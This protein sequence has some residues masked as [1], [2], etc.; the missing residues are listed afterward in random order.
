MM[1]GAAA[2]V[3][4]GLALLV[5]MLVPGYDRHQSTTDAT[6]P[7]F[8]QDQGTSTVGRSPTPPDAAAAPPDPIAVGRNEG[9]SATAENQVQLTPPQQEALRSFAQAHAGQQ[10]NQVAFTVAVGVAVPRQVEL[11]DVTPELAAAFPAHAG[12][13]YLL[14]PGRLV[15]VEPETRRVVAILP[16]AA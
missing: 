11:Q 4:V 3:L 14:M 5:W 10:A 9:I 6:G 7:R 1:G 12:K 2:A 13:Q 16:T 15:V 8:G